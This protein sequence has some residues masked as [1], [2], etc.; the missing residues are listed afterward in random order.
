MNTLTGK[1]AVVTG[2]SKG[3]GAALA[4]GLAEAGAAVAVNYAA[5]KAGA[6][7]TVLEITRG[8]GKAVAIQAD[9]SKATDVKRLFEETKQAFGSID[10]LVNNAGV[11]QFEPFEDI[12]E[13]EFHREFDTNV[14][15]AILATQEALKYFP[16]TG[17]SVINISSL[18]SKNPVPNSSLYSATKSAIDAL[19]MALSKELGPRNIRINTVAPGLIDTEGNRR[20]GFVGSP[21]GD[22]LAAA[23]PLGAR[24][25]RPEEV[26][27]AVVFLASDDAAW[28]T[29]ERISASGGLH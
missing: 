13:K 28:L 24:F 18:A 20:I 15:G 14:L 16:R 8:G 27:P 26:A 9:V 5:D 1:V 4:K 6:E 2:A 10:V 25:G 19:T 22:A 12:T 7:R 3:I 21:E 29:G 23:T 17:G 11:F